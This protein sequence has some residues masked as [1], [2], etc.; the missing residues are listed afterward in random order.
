MITWAKSSSGYS[1]IGARIASSSSCLKTGAA[2]DPWAQPPAG[3]ARRS[4]S[5]HVNARI[6]FG[7]FI[8]ILLFLNIRNRSEYSDCKLTFITS[9]GA[10]GTPP[11]SSMVADTRLPSQPRQS[12]CSYQRIP[13]SNCCCDRMALRKEQGPRD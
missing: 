1:A 7:L 9:Q 13:A 10:C 2:P 11:A 12:L 5:N 8:I 6:N 4:T 3:K